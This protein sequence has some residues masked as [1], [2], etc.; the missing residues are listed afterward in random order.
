MKYL[1]VCS[2]IEAAT[3][4]WQPL[5]WQAVGFSEIE[6]FPNAVLQHHYPDVP[7]YGDMNDFKQWPDTDF[8][9]LVGG[10]PCTSFSI[11]GLRKGLAD[12]NGNLALVYLAITN[13]Y[14]PNWLVWENVPGVLSS[15]SHDAPDPRRS[16]DQLRVGTRDGQTIFDSYEAEESHAFGCFLAGLQK[17]GYGF[18]YRTLN[19]QYFG[20]PQRRRRVFVVGYLGDW[21]RAA[22]VLFDPESLLRNSPPSGETRERDTYDVA[23]Y[24]KA[25]GPGFDRVG[26]GR[27]QDCLIPIAPSLTGNPYGDNASREALLVPEVANP[28]TARMH[29][30]INTTADECQTP[31]VIR[32]SPDV[33]APLTA[34]SSRPGV[35]APGRRKED[36]EN[37]CV[38]HGTQDPCTSD[39][40]FALGQNHGQENVVAFAQNQRDEVRLMD[41]SGTLSAEPGAKQQTYIHQDL[42]IRRLTPTECSRLQQFPDD[43]LELTYGNADEAHSAQILHELWREAGKKETYPKATSIEENGKD[44]LRE[45]RRI[46]VALLTPEILLAG[47]HVGW[48]Q[49]AQAEQYAKRQNISHVGKKR[50]SAGFLQRLREARKAGRSPYRRKSYEQLAGELRN[51]LSELPLEASPA[52]AFLR[53][54]KLW[55]QAQRTWPLRYAHSED[56]SKSSN[57]PISSDSAVY[58]SLGNSMAVP[59]MRWIGERIAG[60]EIR[61]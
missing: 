55:P 46:F 42:A 5:G 49:W 17:L 11:A 61:K 31:I 52:R 27:G 48:L 54:S 2:G 15:T 37:L 29:K 34:G 16:T 12:P 14:R 4:A 59:C 32:G 30:G 18:A 56:A 26:D 9:V 10:T 51:T 13:R 57:R 40:A 7:N 22:A 25:S 39:Q 38:V 60:M 3:V 19:A 44:K 58:K 45:K 36:D 53:C 20:V 28:L 47:V 8:D 6:K 1:S 41:Q 23:P 24:L 50:W 21:R 43:Y 33:A 35:N